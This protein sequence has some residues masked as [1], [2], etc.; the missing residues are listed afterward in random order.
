MSQRNL[1][2]G[3]G[4]SSTSHRSPTTATIMNNYQS[5]L[6]NYLSEKR[7]EDLFV[8]L[9]Q[10]ICLERPSNVV[11]F[12]Q[13]K[14]QQLD[15]IQSQQ[16]TTQQQQQHYSPT[17]PPPQQ[18][19]QQQQNPY[20]N[21]NT[22]TMGSSAKNQP[23]TTI[24]KKEKV[25]SPFSWDSRN[26]GTNT[27]FKSDYKFSSSSHHNVMSPSNQQQQGYDAGI[28]WNESEN[29]RRRYSI[30][31]PRRR[32]VSSEPIDESKLSEE[33]LVTHQKTPE[34]ILKIKDS[35]ADN[36]LFKSLEPEELQVVID[37]MKEMTYKPGDII[38][39]QGDEQADLFFVIDSG[40][41]EVLKKATGEE[42]EKLVKEYHSGDS[43]GELA[44]IYGTPRQA[45]VKAK[46]DVKCWAINRVTFRKIVMINTKRKREMYEDFLRK[47]PILE[48]LTDYERMTVADA[49]VQE[50]YSENDKG[51]CIIRQGDRGDSFYIVLQGEVIVKKINE[52]GE[53]STLTK[54]QTG[55]Y[56]GEIALLTDQPRQAS[57]FISE[58]S[59]EDIKVLR[60][61]RK[62]FK[63][64][65]GPCEEI[66]KRNM[67][68]YNQYVT[69]QI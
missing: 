68:L 37:T 29:R 5:D 20:S 62:D 54:L 58:N 67:K 21:F 33:N 40:E 63:N 56:F 22:Y 31:V 13:Q 16:P 48:T 10:S 19:T 23:T 12:L 17:S 43:F 11:S 15:N 52:N 41:C 44:L 28:D 55:D 49:L 2:G 14:L 6:Q 1:F 57:V 39:R 61:N 4:Y 69:T 27:V 50:V 18:S 8:T 53:E 9:M 36:A 25:P 45:T 3:G 35:L 32:A 60:L 34:E 46:T 47:V 42:E 24:L 66:L 38:I 30:A 65:L 7:V 26:D 59:K 51:R 64:L